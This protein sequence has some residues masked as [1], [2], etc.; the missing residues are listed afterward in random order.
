M[1]SSKKK[2]QEVKRAEN[3]IEDIYK[4]I[5]KSKGGKNGKSTMEQ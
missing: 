4:N 1:K 2:K 3:K 5:T